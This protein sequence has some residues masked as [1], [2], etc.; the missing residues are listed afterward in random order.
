[1]LTD[2]FVSL[3]REEELHQQRGMRGPPSRVP[4]GATQSVVPVFCLS[5]VHPSGLR[6]LV[7]PLYCWC[8]FCMDA[9][10]LHASLKN[11]WRHIIT[12]ITRSASL[13]RLR[14]PNQTYSFVFSDHCHI[15]TASLPD[16]VLQYLRRSQVTPLAKPKGGHTPLLMISFLRTLALKAVIAANTINHCGSGR[17][18]TEWDPRTART[19]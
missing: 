14:H 11:M 12:Q 4:E 19:R 18:N 3:W 13:V 7:L 1:M 9:R 2:I 10:T 5:L 16:V 6:A 17:S 8:I 15:A